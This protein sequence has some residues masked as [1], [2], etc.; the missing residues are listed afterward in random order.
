MGMRDVIVIGAGYAGVLAANRL[1]PHV[2]VRIVDPRESFV[3]RIRLHEVAAGTRSPERVLRRLPNALDRR[4][5]PVRGRARAVEPGLVRLDGGVEL[6]ADHVLLAHG[7]GARRPGSVDTYEDALLARERIAALPPG[8]TLEVVG[9]GLT[10]VELAAEVATAFPTLQ[11]RLVTRDRLGHDLSPAA[12]AHL[13]TRLA[14]FGIE[15]GP[16]AVGADLVLDCTGFAPE[17]LG[18]ESGLGLDLGGRIRSDEHH[19]ILDPYGAPLDGLWGAGDAMAIDGWPW[20]RGGCA[21]AEPLG[22]SAADNIRRVVDGREPMP[23]DVGFALRCIGLGR[24]EA[25]VQVLTPDDKPRGAWFGGRLAAMWKE[26]IST[27]AWQVPV[28]LSRSYRSV[29]GPAAEQAWRTTTGAG[30]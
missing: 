20:L 12:A 13:A 25:L 4:V 18:L 9:A 24:R 30:E 7:R 29:R 22:A 10:G 14:A 26:S 5:L 6:R 17:P 16:V 2:R 3:N 23:A 28:R 8:A 11:V 1:A 19:R 27:L 21:A 15:V